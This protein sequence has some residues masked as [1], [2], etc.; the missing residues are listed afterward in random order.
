MV[1][2]GYYNGNLAREQA[3]D[4]WK[5]TVS[6]ARFI[7]PG[8]QD[9]PCSDVQESHDRDVVRGIASASWDCDGTESSDG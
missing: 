4:V 5:F 3:V 7:T 8:F 6:S 1:K 2:D 9:P